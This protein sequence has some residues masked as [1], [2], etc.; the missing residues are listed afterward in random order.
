MSVSTTSNKEHIVFFFSPV[1]VGYPVYS[2]LAIATYT[3]ATRK[4]KEKT[5]LN[6][7]GVVCCLPAQLGLY[8]TYMCLY[9]VHK[10]AITSALRIR[11]PKSRPSILHKHMHV[12]TY[13]STRTY[14]CMVHSTQGMYTFTREKFYATASVQ[15][16]QNEL[17]GYIVHI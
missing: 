12:R 4:G 14:A 5:W 1:H 6:R 13:V 9:F 3:H 15:R 10:R 16:T 2:Y 11:S 8:S 7:A 17:K